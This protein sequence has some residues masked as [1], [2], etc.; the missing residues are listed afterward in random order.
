MRIQ[1]RLC[2]MLLLNDVVALKKHSLIASD[3][4]SLTLRT[5]SGHLHRFFKRCTRRHQASRCASR[6]RVRSS[7][8]CPSATRDSCTRLP[9]HIYIRRETS[10]ASLHLPRAR[11]R[12]SKLRVNPLCLPSLHRRSTPKVARICLT[13]RRRPHATLLKNT[14]DGRPR[15]DIFAD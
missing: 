14:T 5:T 4:N 13:Y 6:H 7:R 3:Y 12:S 1:C 2:S 10:R 15:R 9:L 11:A 8:A